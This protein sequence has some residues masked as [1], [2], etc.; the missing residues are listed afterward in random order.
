VSIIVPVYNAEKYL[1][2]CLD[3][4]I[5][6]SLSEC[7]ILCV[8]DGSTDAS[9]AILGDY[10]KRDGRIK[11]IDKT[12]QGQGVARNAGL[13]AATGKYV[14]FVDSD[15]Y[16]DRD[17]C[18][19][20][21]ECA[22]Q[23]QA[24]VVMYDYVKCVEDGHIITGWDRVSSLASVSA[25][26]RKTLLGHM[27]VVWTK[28]VRL[29]WLRANHICFPQGRIYED[30]FVHWR[31]LTLADKL[32]LLPERMYYYRINAAATTCRTDWKRADA[33]VVYDMIKDMLVHEH[34]YPQYRDVFLLR[35]L[36]HFRSLHDA[37]EEPYK[38]QVVAMIRER[39][40]DDAWLYIRGN[41][42]LRW[43]DRDFYLA[44]RGCIPAKMRRAVWLCARACYRE[45]RKSISWDYA[46]RLAVPAGYQHGGF[47]RGPP[48]PVGTASQGPLSHQHYNTPGFWDQWIR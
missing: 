5:R 14:A 15:D 17:L 7:E 1:R 20:A 45:A 25:S 19:R 13:A 3:S 43:Q 32:A 30:V 46:R 40:G 21:Y 47:H 42:A 23:R 31:L 29:E 16:V 27:G 24:D 35:Q 33:I 37:M 6:Q 8:N 12:N 9:P 34:L 38:S 22:E 36:G 39:L 44:L 48:S 4:L 10:A 28:L 26:D 2:V 11:V 41:N 18:R